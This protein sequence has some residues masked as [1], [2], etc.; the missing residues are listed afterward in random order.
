ML[1]CR[2]WVPGSRAESGDWHSPSVSK[3]LGRLGSAMSLPILG[4]DFL[5]DKLII[6]EG[7]SLHQDTKT[8]KPD[9]RSLRGPVHLYCTDYR[10]THEK[11]VIH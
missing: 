11:D 3:D 6:Q 7:I 4:A 5:H 8:L 2:S 1:A 10:K 9:G